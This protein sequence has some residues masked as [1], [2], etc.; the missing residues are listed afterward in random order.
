MREFEN[1][2]DNNL[3]ESFEEK[4][5]NMENFSRR[6]VSSLFDDNKSES[7]NFATK[8]QPQQKLYGEKN[9]PDVQYAKY[10]ELSAEENRR[11]QMREQAKKEA[12]IKHRDSQLDEL[13]QISNRQETERRPPQPQEEAAPPPPRKPAPQAPRNTSKPTINV[14]N[15]A[16]LAGFFVLVIFGILVWQ[17][18]AINGR[19]A[20]ATDEIE[21]LEQA[22]VELSQ[23]RAENASLSSRIETLQAQIDD[24]TNLQYENGQN[25]DGEQAP[26]YQ[27]PTTG[28]G[29]P[30]DTGTPGNRTHLV[31]QG[32]TLWS[33]SV[34]FFGDGTRVDDI[35]AANNM[36]E[37]D[38]LVTGTTINIPN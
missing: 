30:D 12:A 1:K 19:L 25:Y 34:A 33:V 15:V 3:R 37:G 5:G 23:L 4:H 20:E 29:T 36:S 11:Q 27:P 26:D 32:D 6:A 17:M 31:V 24:L 14:R 21:A 18:T 35:R 10:L 9:N 16:S 22:T 2:N 13:S 7:G 8:P 38:H 28:P